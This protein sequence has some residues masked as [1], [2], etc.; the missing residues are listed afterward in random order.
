[1]IIGP[2]EIYGAEIMAI[3]FI[4]EFFCGVILRPWAKALVCRE[5]RK[6]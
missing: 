4:P 3:V 1:M 5:M 2:Y 6:D